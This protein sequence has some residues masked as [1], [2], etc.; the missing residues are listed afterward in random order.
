MASDDTPS[1]GLPDPSDQPLSAPLEATET[2]APA[3]LGKAPQAQLQT[4]PAAQ[5]IGR[6]AVLSHLG[7]GGMGSVYAAFDPDLDRRV[8]LKLVR[9]DRESRREQTRLL[10]EARALAQLNHSNVVRIYD[11]GLHGSQ[12][13][14][15]MEF[16][17]GSSLRPWL[18]AHRPS[19]KRIL[20]LF[21]GVARG[22]AAAHRQGL[23]HRDLKLENILVGEDGEARIADFGI[24]AFRDRNPDPRSEPGS[25]AAADTS[26]PK[27]FPPTVV[28]RGTPGYMAPEVTAGLTADERSDQFSFCVALYASLF[29][30]LPPTASSESVAIPGDRSSIEPVDR[31]VLPAGLHKILQ[32]GLSSRPEDRFPSMAALEQDLM[33]VLSPRSRSPWLVLGAVSLLLVPLGLA[34]LQVGTT[35]PCSSGEERLLGIWDTERRQQ[36]KTAFLSTGSSFAAAAFAEVEKKL[37]LYGQ[38]WTEMHR[39]V[40]L[41]TEVHQQQS[42]QLYDLRMMCLEGRR[43]EMRS[44][45]ELLLSVTEEGIPQVFRATEALSPLSPCAESS[46]L[47]LLSPLPAEPQERRRIE[48]LQTQVAKLGVRNRT[49]QH[50]DVDEVY[51]IVQAVQ[52]AGYPP[53]EAAALRQFAILQMRQEADSAAATETMERALGAALA[54]NDHAQVAALYGQLAEYYGYNRGDDVRGQWWSELAEAALLGLATT[55][56]R[57]RFQ[58]HASLG[59]TAWSQSRFETA[60]RHWGKALNYSQQLWGPEH[61]NSTQLLN[62]L[63]L[64]PGKGPEEKRRLLTTSLALK[65]K[66]YG[67]WN[68]LLANTLVN[69][70]ALL[71][72]TGAYAVALNHARRSAEVLEEFHGEGHQDLAFPW[73]LEAD[74][75]NLLDRPREAQS[76]LEQAVAIAQDL[77]DRHPAHFPL[78]L[79]TAESK[80]LQLEL[81]EANAFLKQAHATL[82]PDPAAQ[83]YY[84]SFLL[85]RGRLQLLRR[86]PKAALETLLEAVEIIDNKQIHPP[87]W[88]LVALPAALG[89]AY[90]ET[91]NMEAAQHHL[92]AA[93]GLAEEAERPLAPAAAARLSL[94]RLIAEDDP[95]RADQL[96]EQTATLPAEVYSKWRH[97]LA[98]EAQRWLDQI[99]AQSSP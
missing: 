77:G 30:K 24:A 80:I 54:A 78:M 23:I 6:Y 10:Q 15:A 28:L 32:R 39:E 34:F 89:E 2:L 14:F 35:P 57:S 38:D 94:A 47:A 98:A 60:E 76:R 44:A 58:I 64:L 22:L 25:P 82:R 73:I 49:G 93:V 72:D 91:G 3:G 42:Q 84:P 87:A 71:A 51:Q 11:V 9:S 90:S 33:G 18:Q 55:E 48:D 92:E 53:L 46:R 1:S 95:H 79:A 88:D 86:R 75:L 50:S 12:V 70:G 8:A 85:A 97:S 27:P 61:G 40:C 52:Q 59:L 69:L 5:T 83:P 36:L 17:S 31:S 63:A 16:V 37:D 43:E 96:A 7:S 68:P 21:G 13:F 99:P 41:A 19:W 26:F 4:L 29:G 45:T 62:N 74:I 56:Y 67:A 65:E 66:A 20:R 81:D